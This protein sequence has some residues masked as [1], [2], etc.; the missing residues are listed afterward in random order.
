M[1]KIKIALLLLLLTTLSFSCKKEMMTYE[2]NIG[3]YFAVQNGD[4]YLSIS[5]WPYQPTSTVSFV[6]YDTSEIVFPLKVR[7]TGPVEDHDRFFNVEV[8]PDSTTA[9]LDVHYKAIPTQVTIPAGATEAFVDVHLLRAPDLQDQER[10][11]GL[12]LVPNEYFE[13]SFPEWHAL[14]ELTGGDIVEEFDASMHTLHIND[15]LVEPA[16][17]YG[18]IQ[19]GNRESGIFGQFTR[20]KL[21]LMT[22]VMGVT[23]ADFASEKSMPLVRA[24]L[25]TN[26]MQAYLKKRYNEGDPVLEKDGRLMWI[27]DVPWTSY[28]GVPWVPGS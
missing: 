11:L 1:H 15:F 24:M 16:V 27:G 22:Q 10:T 21:D 26:E 25:I 12:R 28:I 5:Q 6:S 18:S 23:Y 2:G 8:N 17:W 14:P 20:E 19:A 13:L 9:E 3:V 4:D 7:V